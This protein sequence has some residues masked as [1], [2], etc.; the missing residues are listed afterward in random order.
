MARSFNRG[1]LRR[2]IRISVTAGVGKKKSSRRQAWV[3][4]MHGCGLSSCRAAAGNRG[5][6]VA[7]AGKGKNPAEARMQSIVAWEEGS[8]CWGHRSQDPG[9]GAIDRLIGESSAG[10]GSALSSLH[11]AVTCRRFVASSLRILAR[12][13]VVPF[14]VGELPRPPPPHNPLSA[15]HSPRPPLPTIL[16]LRALHRAAP[17]LPR[18]ALTTPS[19]TRPS[20]SR[21]LYSAM[22][23]TREQVAI[24]GSGNW[25]VP[26]SSRGFATGGSHAR[27][28][29]R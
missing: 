29:Y 5:G 12:R 4:R 27:E 19:L 9:G 8:G 15:S 22:T 28:P 10:R 7:L 14:L 24:L 13:I 6:I 16:S 23:D 26:T 18:L 21:R 20:S 11:G 3:H 17:S 2:D 25:C 1:H